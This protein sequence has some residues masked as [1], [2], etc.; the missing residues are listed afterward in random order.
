M[1][2][3]WLI[4]KTDKPTEEEIKEIEA[5]VEKFPISVLQI[6]NKRLNKDKCCIS[7]D[8]VEL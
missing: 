1:T 8:T 3:N 5:M 2:T 7:I 4:L 6:L